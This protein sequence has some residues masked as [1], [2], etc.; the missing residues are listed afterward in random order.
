MV[1]VAT[2]CAEPRTA[3]DC[4]LQLTVSPDDP[5]CAGGPPVTLSWSSTCDPFTFTDG[6]SPGPKF[7][8]DYG[9]FEKPAPGAT[10]ADDVREKS[11]GTVSGH[12]EAVRLYPDGDA[13]E[14]HV[15]VTYATPYGFVGNAS[16]VV[17][18][19]SCR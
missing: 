1:C 4:G 2:A 8:T 3:K 5:H 11:D 17:R 19:V 18:F 6:L 13:G 9:S 15:E 16:A 14:A 12:V 7:Q 10:S